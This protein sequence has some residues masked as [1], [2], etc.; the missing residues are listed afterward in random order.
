MEREKNDTQHQMM[1]QDTH[2]ILWLI[3]LSNWVIDKK[4]NEL[5]IFDKFVSFK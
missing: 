2:R 1:T 3:Q 5:I 4:V